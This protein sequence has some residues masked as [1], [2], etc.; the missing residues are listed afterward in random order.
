M[1]NFIEDWIAVLK[2]KSDRTFKL[3]NFEVAET[4]IVRVATGIAVGLILYMVGI[5][6]ELINNYRA[7]MD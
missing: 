5:F 2:G 4:T 1:R 3:G 7:Y 6:A